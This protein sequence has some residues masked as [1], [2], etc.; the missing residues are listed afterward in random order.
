MLG[1]PLLMYPPL[2]QR[3]PGDRCAHYEPYPEYWFNSFSLI[4][5]FGGGEIL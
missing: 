3:Q 2:C 4:I 1:V 5:T